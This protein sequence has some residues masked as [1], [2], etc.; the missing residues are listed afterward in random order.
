MGNMSAVAK[1]LNKQ[2]KK[3]ANH[4]KKKKLKD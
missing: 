3:I 1:V 4:T 2:P